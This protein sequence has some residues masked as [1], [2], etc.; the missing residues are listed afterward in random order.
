[1]LK[2][3]PLNYDIIKIVQSLNEILHKYK[4]TDV[5]SKVHYPNNIFS[6]LKSVLTSSLGF[7]SKE[8]L[9][10]LLVVPD[11][12]IKITKDT[13]LIEKRAKGDKDKDKDKDKEQDHKTS[14]SGKVY[15]Q[16]N[17]DGG[18]LITPNKALMGTIIPTYSPQITENRNDVNSFNSESASAYIEETGYI[19]V[20]V[21]LTINITYR[22]NEKRVPLF[23]SP[24]SSAKKPESWLLV[25]GICEGSCTAE[26]VHIKSL[27]WH[28][29]K[30][31][32][33][34]GMKQAKEYSI[35]VFLNIPQNRTREMGK[36]FVWLFSDCYI[37]LD[38]CFLIDTSA[39]DGAVQTGAQTGAATQ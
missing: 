37:G 34:T 33:V 39:Q 25:V 5:S 16:N 11:V 30:Y 1:M 14:K 12:V 31:L 3:K 10:Q 13:E 8:L 28:P 6:E 38:R 36:L 32:R 24:F 7:F 27:M 15:S 21:K 9:D 23:K 20:S 22:F 19:A 35:P 26:D 29:V 18:Y 4:I 17:R 2:G